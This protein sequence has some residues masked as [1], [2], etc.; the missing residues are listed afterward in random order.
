[1]RPAT[2]RARQHA[3]CY[4]YTDSH[5]VNFASIEHKSI[6]SNGGHING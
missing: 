4:R 6:V 1:M 3:R 2:L 5:G